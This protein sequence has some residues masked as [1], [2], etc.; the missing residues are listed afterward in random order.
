MPFS[1]IRQIIF[2]ADDTLW[3]N[4]IYFVRA[5]QDFLNWLR[6]NG[7]DKNKIH[8]EFLSL[9]KQVVR[10]RG[11][12]S[13]NFEYILQTLFA[14]YRERFHLS[15]SDLNNILAAFNEHR[16]VPPK[17]FPGVDST[18]QNLQKKYDLYLLTKGQ[19]N[20]QALKIEQSGLKDYFKECFICPEKDDALYARLIRD[21][22]FLPDQTCMVGNS[23]KSD[24]NPALRNGMKAVFIP[25][26]HTWH[27]DNEQLMAMDSRVRQIDA[28]PQLTGIF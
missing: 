5:T 24:I 20:E 25:Y 13:D 19:Q 22:H 15:P 3:I 8:K 10:E 12:G 4:N 17:L 26:D 6:K 21:H 28:F 9:E 23:P 18:L 1:S 16:T 2:D 27:M 7:A 14:R 11:Y